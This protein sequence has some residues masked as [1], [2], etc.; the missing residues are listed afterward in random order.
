VAIVTPTCA[1]QPLGI[2]QKTDRGLCAKISGIRKLVKLR[3]P[4]RQQRNFSAGKKT[5]KCYQEDD[6]NEAVAE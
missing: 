5:V 3:P 2:R 6:Q 4:D 1:E